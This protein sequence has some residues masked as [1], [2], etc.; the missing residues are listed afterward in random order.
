[1]SECQIHPKAL[2]C[3]HMD[4]HWVAEYPSSAAGR[5]EDEGFD[6]NAAIAAVLRGASV[7]LDTVTVTNKR[8]PMPDGWESMPSV[9]EPWAEALRGR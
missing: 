3:A 6:D 2:R 9:Y 5:D 8:L 4:G 1:M 7:F